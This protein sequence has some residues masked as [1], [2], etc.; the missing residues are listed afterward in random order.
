MPMSPGTGS[1]RRMR[2]RNPWRFSSGVGALNG[3]IMTPCGLKFL[4]TWVIVPSLP[5]VSMPCRTTSR[6]RLCSA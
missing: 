1:R 4:T 3:V 5:L 2:Q 6:E